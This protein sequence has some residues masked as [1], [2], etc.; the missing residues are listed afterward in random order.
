MKKDL[1]RLQGT[2]IAQSSNTEGQETPKAQ[3]EVMRLIVKADRWN[4][5]IGGGKPILDPAPKVVLNAAAKPM[6]LD[7]L[8][9]KEK[10]KSLLRAIY[11]IEGDMLTICFAV[12][13]ADRPKEFKSEPGSK[14]GITVYKRLK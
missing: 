3:L 2:W 7:V 5:S 4:Y 6:T 10:G 8:S 14:S 9:E 13:D 1:D 11:K 12:G